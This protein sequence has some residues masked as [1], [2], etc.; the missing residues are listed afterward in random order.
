MKL[1][2]FMVNC[3][4][5]PSLLDKTV[6]HITGLQSTGLGKILV[7]RLRE[8]SLLTPSSRGARVHAT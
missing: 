7:P 8:Y 4:Y 2:G 5:G 6:D 1:V 3:L